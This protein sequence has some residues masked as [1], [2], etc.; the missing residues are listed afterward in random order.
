MRLRLHIISSRPNKILKLYTGRKCTKVSE[1]CKGFIFLSF[2]HACHNNT[3]PASPQGVISFFFIR[4]LGPS[5][6]C[7]PPPPPPKKKNIRNI[8]HPKKSLKFCKRKKY[9]HSVHLPWEKTPIYIEITPITS[10]VLWW[11]PKNIHKI[12]IFLKKKSNMEI[13]NFDSQKMSKPTYV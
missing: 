13:Q 2:S 10:P 7:L 12:F 11:P 3:E 9:P 6:Y 5:I 8:K 4:R 1:F